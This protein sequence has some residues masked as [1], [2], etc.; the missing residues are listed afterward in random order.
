MARWE[1]FFAAWKAISLWTTHISSR[2]TRLAE[3]LDLTICIHT[4]SGSRYLMQPFDVERNHT[5]AH[6]RVCRWWRFAIWSPI[7]YPSSFPSCV[8]A[9]SKRPR[10]GCRTSFMCCA[11]PCAPD[12]KNKNPQ[13]LFRDYRFWVACEADEELPHLLSYIGEDHIVIG[14]DY[15]HNDPSKE[16]EFVKICAPAKTC[17]PWSSKRSCARMPAIFT[18]SHKATPAKSRNPGSFRRSL[19]S[20]TLNVHRNMTNARLASAIDLLAEA[21]AATPVPLMQ[22]RK[23]AQ[24]SYRE[25]SLLPTR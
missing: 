10:A 5:F 6:N 14:S 17:R 1:Y 7:V 24:D 19:E 16:P 2:F 23:A 15:G 3:K 8:S 18:A 13:D 20:G 22:S 11:A 21:E 12:L 9:S 4:G 25:Y